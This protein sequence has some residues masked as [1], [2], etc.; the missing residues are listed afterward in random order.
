VCQSQ[1][2][3]N[4]AQGCVRAG[5]ALGCASASLTP[6][7]VSAASLDRDALRPVADLT[8][9]VAPGNSNA[10]SANSSLACR[11]DK[12][13]KVGIQDS[14]LAISI[15]INNVSIF[16]M[17]A[18]TSI[19]PSIFGWCSTRLQGI[20]KLVDIRLECLVL[21]FTA[22]YFE[23]HVLCMLVNT[24]VPV[25]L[26]NQFDAQRSVCFTGELWELS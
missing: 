20:A 10:T 16:L 6:P 26:Q 17:F 2:S 11:L 15:A 22:E 1:P 7:N 5:V 19:M 9:P 25:Y 14:T 3:S 12:D 24:D 23:Y 4:S 21:V 8:M 13:G 18:Y